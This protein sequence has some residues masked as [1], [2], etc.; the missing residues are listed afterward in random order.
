MSHVLVNQITD[1]QLEW[2]RLEDIFDI[3]VL[4]DL[5]KNPRRIPI[6]GKGPE[7]FKKILVEHFPKEEKNIQKFLDMLKV[8]EFNLLLLIIE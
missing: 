7:E 8:I 3:V 2:I 4:G 1:G 6:M 5:D